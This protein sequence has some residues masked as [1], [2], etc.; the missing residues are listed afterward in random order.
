MRVE[1]VHVLVLHE[2]LLD[3]RAAAVQLIVEPEGVFLALIV[4][5]GDALAAAKRRGL[6]DDFAVLF[7][8]RDELLRGS[9]GGVDPLALEEGVEVVVKEQLAAEDGHRLI[10]VADFPHDRALTVHGHEAVAQFGILA[11]VEFKGEVLVQI[12]TDLRACADVVLPRGA[13]AQRFAALLELCRERFVDRS[14]PT[15][16]QGVV[17]RAVQRV[18]DGCQRFA[19]R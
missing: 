2:H 14:P 4:V 12:A 9:G 10:H 1:A 6:D 19:L 5:R 18:F 13:H 8:K 15:P 16:H 3:H 17:D 11:L 7:Q